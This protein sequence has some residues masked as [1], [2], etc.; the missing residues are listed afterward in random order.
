MMPLNEKDMRQSLM[1]T[2]HIKRSLMQTRATFTCSA[3]HC[4]DCRNTLAAVVISLLSDLKWL[5]VISQQHTPYSSSLF[6]AFM[7]FGCAKYKHERLKQNI[8]I[9]VFI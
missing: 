4:G 1:L 5:Q 8:S 3:S 7:D 6:L 9:C 2:H